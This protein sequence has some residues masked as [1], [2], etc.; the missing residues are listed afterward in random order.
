LLL[1]IRTHT[2]VFVFAMDSA[3]SL[4]LRSVTPGF[5]SIAGLRE[6]QGEGIGW[7]WDRRRLVLTSERTNRMYV[8]E[9]PLP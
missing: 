5:C 3:S 9:C 7:W 4:P 2:D 1:A 8:I 6:K